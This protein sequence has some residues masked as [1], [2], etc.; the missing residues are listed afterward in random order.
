MVVQMTSFPAVKSKVA[1]FS[2]IELMIVVVIVGI[3]SAIAYPSYVSYVQRSQEAEAQ[4]LIMELA[5]SLESYRAKNF[6]YDGADLNV[7]AP[8]L[9]SNKSYAPD[10]E[11]AGQSYTIEAV[12]KSSMMSGMPTLTYTSAGDASWDN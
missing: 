10:L 8:E 9:A 5:S 2:L 7:L 11:A 6:S 1:G 12:P 3:L 4:G